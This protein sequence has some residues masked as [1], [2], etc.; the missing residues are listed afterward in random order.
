MLDG[1]AVRTTR[2]R[3]EGCRPWP[4]SADGSRRT[5]RPSATPRLGSAARRSP[6][7]PLPYRQRGNWRPR[8]HRTVEEWLR[9]AVAHFGDRPIASIRKG[10]VQSFVSGLPL[11]P[12]AVRVVMHHVSGVF[13][14]ALDDGLLGGRNP[15]DGVRLPRVDAPPIFPMSIEQVDALLAATAEPFKAAIVIGAGLGL[16]QSEAAGLAVDRVDFLRR[17]VTIDRQ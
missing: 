5:A 4:T 2:G 6:R 8:T 1:D 15:C 9:Y 12:N 3:V 11:A 16:R 13:N 17:S 14:A 10:D 7:S